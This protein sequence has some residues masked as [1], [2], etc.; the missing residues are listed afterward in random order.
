VLGGGLFALVA[1]ALWVYCILDVVSTDESLMRNLPKIVWL[2]IVI[3]VPTVGSIVWLLL[4]RPVDA[5]FA[6]G[7]TGTRSAARPRGARAV[8]PDDDPRFL[9]DLEDRQRKLQSWEDDLTRREKELKQR[10]EDD[11]DPPAS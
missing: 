10:D 5:G 8:G 9:A 3:F 4:G 1:L 11:P 7:D 2:L 6:P